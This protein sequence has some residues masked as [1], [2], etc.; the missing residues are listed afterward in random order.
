MS[1]IDL[2]DIQQKL[3]EKLK[4][5]GWADRLKGFILSED[6]HNIL[7][8]LLSQSQNGA[9]FTPVLKQLFRAFEECPYNE[10]KV[11]IIGQDPYPKAEVADGIAF[12]CG[13]TGQIQA[14]LRYMFKDI[15]DS[16]YPEGGYSHEPDLARWSNQGVLMLNTA[17]TTTVGKIGVH[18]ELWKP[19]L[20]YLFDML[21]TYN[22]GLVYV[23][24]G[25][26]AKEW[27]TH[28]AKNNFRFFTS[29]PASAAYQGAQRW[30]SGDV[31]NQVNK[32]LMDHYKTQITW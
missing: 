21:S 16:V 18:V 17:L 29:H 2:K 6:F 30:D 20:T 12:S 14:S 26:K 13:N 19:F 31:F 9:R 15:E 4:P 8:E 23:F 22:N 25:N 24:M 11:I 7:K 10:L 1:N 27:R 32:V 3:Y 28:I 5:S